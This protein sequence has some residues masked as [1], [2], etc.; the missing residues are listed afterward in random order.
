MFLQFIINKEILINLSNYY[1]LHIS[2]QQTKNIFNIN[3]NKKNIQF[4]KKHILY[5]Y[6]HNFL[7]LSFNVLKHEILL[8]L[9]DRLNIKYIKHIELNFITKIQNKKFVKKEI[10]FFI[11]NYTHIIKKYFFYNQLHIK[12]LNMEK[13]LIYLLIAIK[14]LIMQKTILIHY[15]Y[16][17]K[18]IYNINNN[19]YNFN[20]KLLITPT[21]N[22]I[23]N[24]IHFNILYNKHNFYNINHILNKIIYF[25]YI[26]K[27]NIFIDNIFILNFKQ[28]YLTQLYKEYYRYNKN[29]HNIM[30]N[31]YN[32]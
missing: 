5:N 9:N 6:M 23:F 30:Y 3:N 11:K 15:N 4:Y 18:I 2:K 22:N 7:L 8:T 20:T 31:I 32:D 1:N 21:Y 13:S 10:L 27:N 14:Y 29:K 19:I 16:I 25:L 12:Q 26:K 17:T 28:Y 24:I